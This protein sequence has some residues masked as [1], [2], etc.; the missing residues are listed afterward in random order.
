[1]PNLATKPSA[2]PASKKSRK[3]IKSSKPKEQ[4]PS[5]FDSSYMIALVEIWEDM[6]E[7]RKG[8]AQRIQQLEKGGVN[9]I[10]IKAMEAVFSDAKKNIEKKIVKEWKK[11]PLYDWSSQVKGLGDHSIAYLVAKLGGDVLTARPVYFQGKGD[12]R[13]RID[14][15]PFQRTVSQLWAYCGYG[16]PERKRRR[17]ASQDE[18]MNAG[19]P[20]LKARLY[21]IAGSFLKAGNERYRAIYDQ[22]KAKYL[23]DGKPKGHAHNCALRKVKKEF[24]KDL[25]LAAHHLGFETQYT[26]VSGRS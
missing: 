18:C 3:A 14:M 5:S 19:N 15:E 8:L 7:D 1:M 21:L 24:L 10:E 4:T 9:P 16:D 22:A 17:G 20:K 11:H 26:D 6:M 12:D 2:T 13:V 25:W 23:E